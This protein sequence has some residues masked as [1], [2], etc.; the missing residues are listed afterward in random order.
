MNNHIIHNKIAHDLVA[1]TYDKKHTE[2]FND[3]EPLWTTSP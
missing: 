2:I 1:K 3:V